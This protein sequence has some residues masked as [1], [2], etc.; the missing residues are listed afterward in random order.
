MVGS[1]TLTQNNRQQQLALQLMNVT[2]TLNAQSVHDVKSRPLYPHDEYQQF[3]IVFHVKLF[4]GDS[5]FY[6]NSLADDGYPPVFLRTKVW[7]IHATTPNICKLS[8]ENGINVSLR[9]RLPDLNFPLSSKVSDS[10]VAGKWYCPFVFIKEGKLIDQVK[11]S[12]F[13]EMTLEQKW[14]QIFIKETEHNEGNIVFVEADIHSEAVFIKCS[15][16]KKKLDGLVLGKKNTEGQKRIYMKELVHGRIFVIGSLSVKAIRILAGHQEFVFAAM[17][18]RCLFIRHASQ[19]MVAMKLMG[20]SSKWGREWYTID[21]CDVS[22]WIAVYLA[23]GDV[24][25]FQL[26]Y[27]LCS[28][29]SCGKMKARLRASRRGKHA[30]FATMEVVPY[31]P[32]WCDQA[33]NASYAFGLW[34]GYGKLAKFAGMAA[35]SSLPLYDVYRWGKEDFPPPKSE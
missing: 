27:I 8:E 11:K 33:A 5:G 12:I 29:L 28:S 17:T 13:Y 6:A 1:V 24:A 19:H 30:K 20:E 14:N 3:E 23:F 18:G 9:S 2:R 34:L 16:K 26:A 15:G 35:C 25:S 4:D 31:F 32:G 22:G 21:L 10:V 7:K